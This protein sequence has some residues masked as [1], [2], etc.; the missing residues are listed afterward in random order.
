M[1]MEMMALGGLAGT[2]MFIRDIFYDNAHGW[3]AVPQQEVEDSPGPTG[4]GFARMRC[5]H[6]DHV[7]ARR[8]DD[9]YDY[10][11]QQ[12]DCAASDVVWPSDD[13]LPAGPR[14]TAADFPNLAR[15]AGRE[16]LLEKLTAGV[17]GLKPEDLD[18]LQRLL[19]LA[20][21]EI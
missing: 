13:D 16:D 20:E 4:G 9:N 14:L 10:G 15:L 8:R 19:D 2:V 5:R 18:E 6:C 17:D 12:D 11:H 3:F 21:E 7:I 1:I